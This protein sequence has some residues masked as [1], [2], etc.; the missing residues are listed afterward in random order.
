[1]NQK[2]KNRKRN[3]SGYFKRALRKIYC[4]SSH[5]MVGSTIMLQEVNIKIFGIEVRRFYN[6]FQVSVTVY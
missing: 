2:T 4:R 1:M 5:S 6:E 3:F